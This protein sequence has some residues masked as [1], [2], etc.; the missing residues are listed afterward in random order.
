MPDIQ[1]LNR[2]GFRDFPAWWKRRLFKRPARP[3]NEIL[4][5]ILA[6][7]SESESSSDDAGSKASPVRVDLS[8]STNGTP[9]RQCVDCLSHAESLRTTPDLP[10]LI[11]LEPINP[12]QI[13]RKSLQETPR[14]GRFIPY[15]EAASSH[16]STTIHPVSC[17]PTPPPLPFGSSYTPTPTVPHPTP[18]TSPEQKPAKLR[19]ERDQ[20]GSD[21]LKIAESY[22]LVSANSSVAPS[23][24]TA[25]TSAKT[26]KPEDLQH[27]IENLKRYCYDVKQAASTSRSVTPVQAAKP[28]KTE[29]RLSKH[30]KSSE[31]DDAKPSSRPSVEGEK[32]RKWR[33]EGQMMRANERAAVPRCQSAARTPRKPMKVAD[34]ARKATDEQPKESVNPLVSICEK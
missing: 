12:Q 33:K 4:K 1:T 32:R 25:A 8:A 9:K 21:I 5:K 13:E 27:Q 11:D 29:L 15:N 34:G 2:I 24:L 23:N 20:E 28:N 10:D 30:A 7:E 3:Q 19:P 6:Q 16:S 14:V 22:L 17:S 31:S 18:A 26:I